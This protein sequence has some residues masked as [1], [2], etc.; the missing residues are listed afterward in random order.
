MH[1]SQYM[2]VNQRLLVAE[3]VI[4]CPQENRQYVDLAVLNR[5]A[6]AGFYERFPKGIDRDKA[7]VIRYA[8]GNILTQLGKPGVS[9]SARK[10]VEVEGDQYHLGDILTEEEAFDLGY[11]EPHVDTLCARIGQLLDAYWMKEGLVDVLRSEGLITE[12]QTF[13]GNT[14]G[15]HVVQKDRYDRLRL[16]RW[17]ERLSHAEKPIT[18]YVFGPKDGTIPVGCATFVEATNTIYEF[19]TYPPVME[20]IE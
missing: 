15:Y 10:R 13:V 5:E 16:G 6:S 2:L 18:L 1:S 19:M 14:D 12:D 17:D 7:D 8:Q 3:T 9:L 20:N 4:T 11:P